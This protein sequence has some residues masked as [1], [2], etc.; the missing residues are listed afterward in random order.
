MIVTA[1]RAELAAAIG[2]PTRV[3]VLNNIIIDYTF[4]DRRIAAKI[5]IDARP[6][7]PICGY[8]RK[9]PTYVALTPMMHEKY[10][11]LIELWHVSD[12]PEI[13]KYVA[14]YDE[15]I[16]MSADLL[17]DNMDDIELTA[18][19]SLTNILG[20]ELGVNICECPMLIEMINCDLDEILIGDRIFERRPIGIP[21]PPSIN[22]LRK[23]I[24]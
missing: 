6:V 1:A 5:L 2:D 12:W 20:F 9:F 18:S 7:Y 4:V 10:D 8:M 14:D 11:V 19:N 22:D 3:L 21:W 16:E 15:V 17:P 23:I 13:P 24:S